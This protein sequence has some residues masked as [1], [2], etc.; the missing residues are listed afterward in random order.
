MRNSVQ[1][2]RHILRR[3][4][5][6]SGP[7]LHYRVVFLAIWVDPDNTPSNIKEGSTNWVGAWWA[8]WYISF[9]VSLMAAVPLFSRAAGDRGTPALG[10]R[11]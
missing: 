1:V 5:A 11:A 2:S 6:R 9:G 8:P 3:F 4:G 10:C 7:R